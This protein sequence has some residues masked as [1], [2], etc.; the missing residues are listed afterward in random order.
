MRMKKKENMEKAILWHIPS[1]KSFLFRK[2]RGKEG[3]ERGRK[4]LM[5]KAETRKPSN[6]I[7]CLDLM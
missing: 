1:D 4:A 6:A 3:R 2:V 7:K 5:L